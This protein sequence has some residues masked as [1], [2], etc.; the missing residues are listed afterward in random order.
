M[1]QVQQFIYSHLFWGFLLYG[2][3]YFFGL[4]YPELKRKGKENKYDWGKIIRLS[5]L[6]ITAAL[7]FPSTARFWAWGYVSW[8]SGLAPFLK[9]VLGV[10]ISIWQFGALIIGPLIVLVFEEK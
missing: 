3:L 9:V 7:L 10:L 2:L 4:I 8:V 6:S 5:V 1:L